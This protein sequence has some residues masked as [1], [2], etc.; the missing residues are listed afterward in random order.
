MDVVIGTWM[1]HE[2]GGG[3]MRKMVVL[4]HIGGMHGCCDVPYL[5]VCIQEG[6]VARA[7]GS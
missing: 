7:H 1:V 5:V 4:L 3:S 6:D 2:G